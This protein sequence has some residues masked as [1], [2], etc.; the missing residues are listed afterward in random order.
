V[1]ASYFQSRLATAVSLR[2]TDHTASV[3]TLY[4]LHRSFGRRYTVREYV[5]F[6]RRPFSA[7]R[8]PGRHFKEAAK[9][10]LQ[11][12]QTNRVDR[13]GGGSFFYRVQKVRRGRNNGFAAL[14]CSSGGM[15]RFN[16]LSI[17]TIAELVA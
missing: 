3:L 8:T 16:Y 14:G 11:S 7:S 10:R 17:Y 9:I 13:P 6:Y 15:N 12:H 4:A 2:Y 1:A 5:G